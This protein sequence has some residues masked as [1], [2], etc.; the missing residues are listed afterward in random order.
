MVDIVL[1]KR[2]GRA[3]QLSVSEVD[4]N[5]QTI[6]DAFANLPAPNVGSVTSVA[7]SVPSIMSVSGSPITGAGIIAITLSN[8]NA[9]LIF[10]GPSSGGAANPSFRSI[11]ANDLPT[12]PLAKLATTTAS[13]VMVTDSSG[14]II[15]SPSI[16]T[17]ELG[18]LDGVTSNIQTQLNAKQATITILPIANGGTGGSTAQAARINVLPA[19]AGNALKYLRVNAGATD[20]EYSSTG[21]LT[22]TAQTI[23]G[24]KTF[25]DGISLP[26]TDNNILFMNGGEVD[27]N[28][29]FSIDLTKEQMEVKRVSIAQRQVA[30]GFNTT[31]H[32]ANYNIDNASDHIIYIDSTSG[33]V[34][35]VLPDSADTS[36]EIGTIFRIIKMSVANNVTVECSGLDEIDFTGTTS[37]VLSAVKGSIDVQLVEVGFY[38]VLSITQAP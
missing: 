24:L 36:T 31:P 3:N 30:L 15:A 12:V 9:N 8:Q 2:S 11:V 35:A 37:V 20:V 16:D 6:Q 22:T 17:T 34:K 25:S 18:Y 4:S 33:N 29:D 13:R 27:G 32:T 23:T 5:W 28:N 38:R 1:N 10:A 19:L 7:V 21:L 14:N 26:E